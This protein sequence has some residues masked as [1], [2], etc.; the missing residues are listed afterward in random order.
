[1]I[2]LVTG[3]SSG[4]GREIAKNL[5]LRGINLI[6]VA[7]RTERLLQLKNEIQFNCPNVKV[8]T[9]TA[10]LSKENQCIELY[11]KLK[12]YNIEFLFNNA[13]FGIYGKYK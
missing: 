3:A 2:A 10:D 7:R 5:A 1:M 11:N 8:K 4:I 13:G 12:D 6:L 9:I